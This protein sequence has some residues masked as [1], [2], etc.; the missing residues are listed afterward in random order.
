MVRVCGTFVV[1]DM[2]VRMSGT[3]W[4]MRALGDADAFC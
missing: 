4:I 2:G 3:G 1:V